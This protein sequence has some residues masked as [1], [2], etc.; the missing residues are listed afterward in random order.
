MPYFNQ[1]NTPVADRK[2]VHFPPAAN[3]TLKDVFKAGKGD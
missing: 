1:N 3:G 2:I